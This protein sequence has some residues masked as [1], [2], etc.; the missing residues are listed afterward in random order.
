LGQQSGTLVFVGVKGTVVAL[1][2]SS[3]SEVW[4]TPLGTSHFVNLVLDGDALYAGSRGKIYC[5]SASSGAIRWKNDL[6]GLGFGLVSI[7]APGGS[8]A[9]AAEMMFQEQAAAAAASSGA[10]TA[11]MP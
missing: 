8:N 6:K 10:M 11:T 9:A 5:L 4:R 2:K 1:E 3:G 7:G